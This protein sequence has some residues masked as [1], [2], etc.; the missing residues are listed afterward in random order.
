MPGTK[1]SGG[2]NAKSRALL[3]LEGTFRKDRHTKLATP[4]P[5]A[6]KPPRPKTLTGTARTEWDRMVA[7]LDQLQTL[8]TV[9]DAA[10][11]QYALLFAE[12]EAIRT[13]RLALKQLSA[14]LM[15]A[16]QRLKGDALVDAATEIVKLQFLLAKHT[17]QLRQGHMALRQYLVEFGMTPAA[18][19]RVTAQP[20]DAHTPVNPVDRFTKARA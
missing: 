9:D 14:D 12:T 5:P 4:A 18:R 15:T 2:R 1:A 6:G 10:L 3:L 19:T 8:S 17:A 16:I 7:R 13:D 20:D 11:Y